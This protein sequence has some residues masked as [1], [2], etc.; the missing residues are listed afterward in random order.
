MTGD[1]PLEMTFGLVPTL[2]VNGINVGRGEPANPDTCRMMSLRTPTYEIV[3]NCQLDGIDAE[4]GNE[5]FRDSGD[6]CS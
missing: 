5:N 6:I 2:R 1:A 3:R 4:R